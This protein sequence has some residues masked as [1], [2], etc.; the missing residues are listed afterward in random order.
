MRAYGGDI[1]LMCRCNIR[2]LE[3]IAPPVS[4]QRWAK[5]RLPDKERMV[6]VE[7]GTVEM[8][9]W[10]NEQ[11]QLASDFARTFAGKELSEVKGMALGANTDVTGSRIITGFDDLT[12]RRTEPETNRVQE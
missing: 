5:S 8:D 12:I 6:I 9:Q 3:T 1:C 10:A 7:R 2:T 4:L 11:V